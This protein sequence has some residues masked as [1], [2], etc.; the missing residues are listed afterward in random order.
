MEREVV[1]SLSV[2]RDEKEEE[3]ERG[4]ETVVGFE[5]R[6]LGG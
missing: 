3:G 4:R 6:V 2:D 1:V 5:E